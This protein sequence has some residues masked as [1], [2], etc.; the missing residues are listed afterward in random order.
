MM[1][2]YGPNEGDGKKKKSF[3]NDLDT[4]VDRV[5]NGYKLCVMGDLNGW[6]EDSKRK[7]N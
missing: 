2:G 1:L 5:G 4:I 3:W 6:I 7:Y